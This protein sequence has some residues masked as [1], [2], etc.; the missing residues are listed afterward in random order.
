[1]ELTQKELN[2]LA[3]SLSSSINTLQEHYYEYLKKNNTD[4]I[5]ITSKQILEYRALRNKIYEQI[6]L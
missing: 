1:M 2:Q 4:L 3:M 5:D 6:K